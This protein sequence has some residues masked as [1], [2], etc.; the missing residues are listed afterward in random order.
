MEINLNLRSEILEYSLNIEESIND[1]ILLY[2]GIYIEN[3]K[4][5]LFGNKGAITFKNKKPFKIG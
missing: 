3:N 5:R 4:T 1:L 2:L